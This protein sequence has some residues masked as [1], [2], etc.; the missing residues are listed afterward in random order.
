MKRIVLVTVALLALATGVIFAGGSS[1]SSADVYKVGFIGP[2]TGDNANYG[3]RCL[4]ATNLAVSEINAKGGISGKLVQIIAEDSEGASEKAL[5]GYEKLVYT[6]KVCAIIGPVFTGESLAVAPRCVEDGIVMISPSAS[7]KDVTAAGEYVFRTTPSDALQS[8]VA[9]RYFYS[10]LGYKNIA[11][12]YAQNDYSKGLASGVKETIEALGGKVVT[13]ETFMVGDKDFRTQLTRIAAKNPEAIY[14]PDYTVEMAQILEQAAQLGIKIPFLSGD[15]FTD[16]KIYDLA[17]DYTNGV[18]YIGPDQAKASTALSDFQA[19]YRKAYNGDEADAFATNA[20]DA[21]HILAEAI[22][23]AGSA[24]RK[25][26]K[27][28]MVATK[29]YQ[30][31]N[32]TL[33]FAANGDLIAS[34]GVYLVVNQTPVYQGSYQVDAN[35]KLVEVK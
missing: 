5:A 13:E 29:D 18:I 6:D 2:L 30:G 26:I 22:E 19:A 33:N 25:A 23:R 9:G 8:D 20:Y 11:N 7:H 24:D 27:D 31:A 15:G 21:M 14:I 28:Q 16:P 1:E 17:G 10:V 4:N 3:V 35:G 32:G 34:Q 12:L